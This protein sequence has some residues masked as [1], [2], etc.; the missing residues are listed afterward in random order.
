VGLTLT[1]SSPLSTPPDSFSLLL[2]LYKM[3]TRYESESIS[4]FRVILNKKTK[5]KKKKKDSTGIGSFFLLSG[6]KT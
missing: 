2:I 3:S 5:K 4:T 6:F 1:V